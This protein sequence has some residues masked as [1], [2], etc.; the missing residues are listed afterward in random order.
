MDFGL[1][2]Q[3]KFILRRARAHQLTASRRWQILPPLWLIA[4]VS[5]A[6]WLLLGHPSRYLW[7]LLLPLLG[8]WHRRRVEHRFQEWAL[9]LR[10]L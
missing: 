8:L 3:Q 10:E 1:S 2:Q 7:L 6:P 5:L 4:L 9:D